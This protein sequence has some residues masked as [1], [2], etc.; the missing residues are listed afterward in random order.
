MLSAG[1]LPAQNVVGD[2]QGTLGAPPNGLRLVLRVSRAD[3]G[4]LNATLVS[5]D[6]GGWDNPIPADSVVLRDSMFAFF[7]SDVGGSYRGTLTGGGS[8]I[9]GEWTQGNSPQRLDFVRPSARTAWRDTSQH[10]ER[11][12]T[13]ERNVRL[14]VLDWGGR[15]RPVVLLAGAG[16]SA[17]IFD[18]FAPKLTR[19]Y[20]VYGITRRGF[21][22]SSHP[23]SGY[24]ADTL[25]N[26]VLAVLDSLGIRAPVL[27]GHSIA[28]EELSSIGS[29]HPERVA[30]LVYLDAGYP[31]ALYDSTL[32]DVGL[33]NANV[34]VSDVQH[35]LARLNDPYLSMS[36]RDQQAL[37]RELL[38]TSLPQMERDLRGKSKQLAALPNQDVTPPAQRPNPIIQA[39]LGGEEKYTAVR[40]PVLAIFAAP[41][42]ASPAVAKD[43]AARAK[44]DSSD[45]AWVMTQVAA[46]R[47]LP[48]ARVVVLPNANHYVFKSNEAEVLRDIRAFI[49]GLPQPT[50]AGEKRDR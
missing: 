41:H 46:F 29:R 44:A 22:N 20:H 48:A 27:I 1:A 23:A 42:E 7:I 50:P 26:D 37:I 28:G 11:L 39:L 34:S 19:E 33:M 3:G 2:W 45:L 5:I 24:L 12:V 6:Q 43:S 49:D 9:R 14:E 31:Y 47:R 30:G 38:E 15:G 32:S 10:S 13:V 18:A 36:P 40:A 16:N 8:A 17:H 35:K 4:A 25:A 21:G